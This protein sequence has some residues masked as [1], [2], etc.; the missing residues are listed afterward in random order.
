M[1]PSN[2]MNRSWFTSIQKLKSRHGTFIWKE[3]KIPGK[4]T[5]DPKAFVFMNFVFKIDLVFQI[6]SLC[7]NCD[8]SVLCD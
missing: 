3:T 6:Y 8:K 1:G 2:T 4:Y 7:E 5:I